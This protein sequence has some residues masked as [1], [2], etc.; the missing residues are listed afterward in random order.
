[1]RRSGLLA[2]GAAAILLLAAG[3]AAAAPALPKELW[4]VKPMSFERAALKSLRAKGVNAVVATRLSKRQRAR[5]RAAKLVVVAPRSRPGLRVVRLRSPGGVL[6]VQRRG[7]SRVLA[8]VRLTADFDSAAWARAVARTADTVWLDLGVL[9]SGLNRRRALRSYLVVMTLVRAQDR[10]APSVPAGLALSERTQVSVRL[11]WRRSRDNR[12]V[13]RYGLYRDG[14]R[15]DSSTRTTEVF[16]GLSCGRTYQLGVDAAD[17]AGNRSARA[18]VGV[19]T[20]AC[21]PGG[22]PPPSPPPAPPG[23]G[24]ALPP[25]LPPSVGQVFYVAPNGSDSNLGTQSAP[26]QTIQKAENT[27]VA[28]QKALVRGGTYVQEVYWDKDGS[29]LAPVTLEAYPGER[30]VLRGSSHALEIVASYVRIRG[31]TLEGG[32]NTNIYLENP[33][34][35]VEIS[36]N[37]IRGSADQGIYVEGNTAG[38][39]ILRN[40]VHHNGLCVGCGHQSHGIYLEGA[41]HL[42]ANNVIHDHP[43]G[44]GIQVYPRNNG[45]IVVGNTAVANGYAGIVLGGS[46]G[47]QNVTVRNNVFANNNQHGIAHDDTCATASVAD[48]N[49][50]YG[51]GAAAIEGGCAGVDRSG[52]NRTTDPFFANLGSRDL[53]IR[54]GSAA[55]DYGLLNWSPIVDFDGVLRTY[56]AG[57]DVGAYERP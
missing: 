28:G 7:K 14:R 23:L 29:P 26:W 42:V 1:M 10:R 37:E 46:G 45:S 54:P 19:T 24:S 49:V 15:V 9:P 35:H 11:S 17:K 33:S 44:F 13:T 56:G 57:P 30:P 51:N 21:A 25:P 55:V 43:D 16:T 12:G 50:L 20:L 31:F 47:V 22:P 38:H 52:G 34:D 53:H 48:H 39:Q 5:V 27:L 2:A 32:Q 18:H 41:A 3:E 6:R 4:A 36:A 40:W 8:L